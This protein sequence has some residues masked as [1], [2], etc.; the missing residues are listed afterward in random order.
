M[1]FLWIKQNVALKMF[2]DKFLN[3]LKVLTLERVLIILFIIRMN[4]DII[5]K[6]YFIIFY[7]IQKKLMTNSEINISCPLKTDHTILKRI[8]TLL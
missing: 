6:P 5:N 3:E 8:R 1:V 2:V 7:R 4:F